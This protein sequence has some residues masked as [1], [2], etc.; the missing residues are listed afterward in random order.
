MVRLCLNRAESIAS[1]SLQE[2]K[3]VF[4]CEIIAKIPSEGKAAMLAMN[5]KVP[6][7]KEF[8]YSKIAAAFI[9]FAKDIIER[10]DIFLK[11]K[12]IKTIRANLSSAKACGTSMA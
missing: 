2:I 4:P 6:L 5:K 7:V 1:I 3:V 12:E 8:P 9:K 11:R 10:P